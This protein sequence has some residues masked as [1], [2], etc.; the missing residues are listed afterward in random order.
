MPARFVTRTFA[1][2]A[3]RTT[4]GLRLTIAQASRLWGLERD[5]CHVLIESLVASAFLRW[6]PD[7]VMRMHG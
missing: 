2:E 6:M 1:T 5:I 4:A 7:A 3:A